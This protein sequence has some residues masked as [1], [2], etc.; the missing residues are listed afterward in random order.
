M[1]AVEG[2]GIG[3]LLL[4][5]VEGLDGGAYG[6]DSL[7]ELCF[8]DEAPVGKGVVAKLGGFLRGCAF[9]GRGRKRD[10]LDGG[11]GL[12]QGGERL[13]GVAEAGENASVSDGSRGFA[14]EEV[15]GKEEVCAGKRDSLLGEGAGFGQ[16]VPLLEVRGD[17]E[18]VGGGDGVA[19]QIGGLERAD[20]VGGAVLAG[21]Q[22]GEADH[23]GGILVGEGEKPGEVLGGGFELRG[24]GR[25]RRSSRLARAS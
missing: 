13:L 19:G 8:G 23:P 14:V 21:A 10:G 4:R 5:G 22:F 2:L 6:G 3:E 12:G 20:G 15:S 16:E 11:A 25:P 18:E 24:I 1:E 7:A 17:G 9:A